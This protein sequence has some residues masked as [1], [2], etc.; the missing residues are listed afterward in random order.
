MGQRE[1]CAA[2]PDDLPSHV[3]IPLLEERFTEGADQTRDFVG[4]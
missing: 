1:S 4:V 2:L 3:L